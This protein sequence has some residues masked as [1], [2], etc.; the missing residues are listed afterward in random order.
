MHVVFRWLPQ[1]CATVLL[2]YPHEFDEM[3]MVEMLH[4]LSFA[5]ELHLVFG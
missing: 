4:N 2:R 5:S 1:G 3:R